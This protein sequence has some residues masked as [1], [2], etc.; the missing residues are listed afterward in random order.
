ME[1]QDLPQV[2][3]CFMP[4]YTNLSESI[5]FAGRIVKDFVY[6]HAITT[7][8][9]TYLNQTI[10]RFSFQVAATRPF[11]KSFVKTQLPAIFICLVVLAT[12]MLPASESVSRISV[13]GSMLVAAVMFH[14]GIERYSEEYKI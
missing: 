3:F 5:R 9:I 1:L 10:S 7:R 11:L 2:T 8:N 4:D 6:S 12:Y 13:C 14:V